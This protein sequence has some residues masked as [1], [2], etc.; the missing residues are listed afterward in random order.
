MTRARGLALKAAAT[1]SQTMSY[2]ALARKW[3][4]RTFSQLLGQ[5][6]VSKALTTSLA[7]KKIHHAYLF[8]G[9][10]GVGKTSIARLFAK[11]LNCEQGISATPCLECH[12]CTAI[13]QNQFIDLIEIDGASKT[14]VEDT[15]E[16]LENVQYAPSAARFKIYL[17]DEV[18]MLSQH[19][20]NALLKTLEEP[21]PHIKF[22][23]AT[24]DPQKIPVTVLSRCLHFTLKHLSI[25][26]LEEQL[27]TILDEEKLPYDKDA[28][29]LIAKAASGSMRDALSLLDQ[30]IVSAEGPLSSAGVKQLLGHTQQEYTFALLHALAKHDAAALIQISHCI[31]TESAHFRHA[32]EAL[33]ACLHEI[34]V[35]QHVPDSALLSFSSEIK[36]LAE[37]INAE[38]IQLFY[39][40]G[41]KGLNDMALA[42]TMAI[43]F[44]M[45]LLRM[46]TFKPHVKISLNP[47]SFTAQQDH[48]EANVSVLSMTTPEVTLAA[49]KTIA[50]QETINTVAPMQP[51]LHERSHDWTSI[52]KELQLTGL[53]QNAVSN[54]EW[55]Q[56]SGAN[57]YLKAAA[58]HQSLF[59]QAVTERIEKSLSNYYQE[60]IKLFVQFNEGVVDTPAQKNYEKKVR[61]QEEAEKILQ[62]DCFLTQL[63][64]EF[65]A[66]FVRNSIEFLEDQL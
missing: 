5:D 27:T 60:T 47:S 66:E 7:L 51:P 18:H 32:L 30:A 45:T 52:V 8:S 61:N 40:I 31:G 36:Q 9:T 46:L 23:L 2:L 29:G 33:L 42:P 64:E 54:A 43:G 38:D 22:L 65:S 48:S 34:T 12:V 16:L 55:L 1:I 63:K 24:T 15:R 10:R 19:S 4:P 13:E 41:I 35:C 53:A 28:L 20:F 49:T 17:I 58:G 59:N 14:R 26:V 44:E 39:Q 3:R 21:P 37:Q 57:I 11:A 6:H 62:N 50:P 25:E 56:K